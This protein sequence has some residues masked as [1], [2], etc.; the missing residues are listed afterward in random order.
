MRLGNQ[1]TV[2][3]SQSA[4]PCLHSVGL[5]FDQMTALHNGNT[6]EAGVLLIRS[7]VSDLVFQFPEYVPAPGYQR[8]EQVSGEFGSKMRRLSIR[9]AG[10]SQTPVIRDVI[11]YRPI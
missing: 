3:V 5:S 10:Y 9:L 6:I 1:V 11:S 8:Q 4:D 2:A 7:S